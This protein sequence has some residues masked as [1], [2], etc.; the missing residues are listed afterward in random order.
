MNLVDQFQRNRTILPHLKRSRRGSIRPFA[1]RWGHQGP[2]DDSRGNVRV[3][4]RTRRDSTMSGRTELAP[5]HLRTRGLLRSTLRF[6]K[7]RT[8]RFHRSA[9]PA[10]LFSAPKARFARHL[11]SPRTSR[12]LSREN[13][14]VLRKDQRL[15][16][17][18][19]WM[20]TSDSFHDEPAIRI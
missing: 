10:A 8:A 17:F 1:P 19:I 18:P 13:D 7:L 9:I 2:D 11:R 14:R 20:R 5:C 12:F 4:R 15:L 3:L 6:L 16:K